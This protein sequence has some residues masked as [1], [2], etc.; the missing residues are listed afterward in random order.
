MPF[1]NTIATTYT[2]L[3][4]HLKEMVGETGGN[5]DQVL[6]A[7]APGEGGAGEYSVPF[8][9][10]RVAKIKIAGNVDGDKEWKVSL[11]F[12]IVTQVTTR[13][14]AQVEILHRIAQVED[15]IDSFER[16]D[17][18]SGLEEGEWSP[19]PATGADAGSISIAEAIKSYTVVVTRGDN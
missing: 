3:M 16:P 19:S 1:R 4:A 8:L 2:A 6:R 15:K 13:V 10:V 17:G 11:K 7:V 12:R 5:S 9:T 18:V 14:D